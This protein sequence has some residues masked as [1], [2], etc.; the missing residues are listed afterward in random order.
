MKTA[1]TNCTNT[2]V[3]YPVWNS[4]SYDIKRHR[5]RVLVPRYSVLGVGRQKIE[6]KARAKNRGKKKIKFLIL[7]PGFLF[8][9]PNVNAS[10]NEKIN[11]KM[12]LC[13]Y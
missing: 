5:Y 11:A 10:V 3:E 13:T 7:R 2:G 4:I 9:N 6:K 8:V 12:V 1:G